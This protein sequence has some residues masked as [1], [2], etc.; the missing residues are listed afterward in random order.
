M[1]PSSK[2]DLRRVLGERRLALTAV[3]VAEGSRAVARHV[4]E[5]PEVQ[6]AELVALYAAL[7]NEID[8]GPI[9]EELSARGTRLC[10]PR[11]DDADPLLRFHEAPAGVPLPRLGKHRVREPDAGWPLVAAREIPVIVIPGVGFCAGG[12]RLGRGGG[13]YD[14]LLASAP[15]ALRVAL[16]YDFQVVQELPTDPCD[17]PID[18]LVTETGVR[19]TFHDPG[20]VRRVR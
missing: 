5:L 10:Y 16:A 19:R 8:T 18:V 1:L 2:A 3:E 14:R 4:L 7:G 17:E 6:R 9:A 12:M 13:H 15:G 11:L 20:Q